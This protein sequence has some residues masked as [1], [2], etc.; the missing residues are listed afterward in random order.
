MR[1]LSPRAPDKSLETKF[2]GPNSPLST[3][4]PPSTY[5]ISSLK[6]CPPLLSSTCSNSSSNSNHAPSLAVLIPGRFVSGSLILVWV[7]P[8]KTWSQMMPPKLSAMCW[9]SLRRMNSWTWNFGSLYCLCRS[10]GMVNKLQE[11]PFLRLRSQLLFFKVN[12]RRYQL[13]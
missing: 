12:W 7:V 10:K 6:I 3:P 9:W 11:G 1:L 13:T 4:L 2:Q 8:K 5:R